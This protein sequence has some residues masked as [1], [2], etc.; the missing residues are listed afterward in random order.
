V[1]LIYRPVESVFDAASVRTFSSRPITL[2][3][4]PELVTPDNV[5]EYAVGWTGTKIK[6]NGDM[7]QGSGIITDRTAINAIE[8]GEAMQVSM[9]YTLKLD[10]TPGKT[11]EGQQY[12]GSQTGLRMNHLAVV[13]RARGGS[14]LKIGDNRKEENRT[15]TVI[16]GGVAVKV[17]DG[18][19]TLTKA[20][21]DHESTKAKLADAEAKA[22]TTDADWRGK[23]K[24]ME[25]EIARLKKEN[26]G[27][28]EMDAA[29]E[30]RAKL[31][32]DAAKIAPAFETK[33]KDA[34][35]IRKGVVASVAGD[36]AVADKSADYIA[37][38][39]DA[40]LDA[41]P[42]DP[43]AAPLKTQAQD[44]DAWGKSVFDAAGVKMK[45]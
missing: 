9:G 40:L 29:V 21:A 11:P 6:R 1:K 23:V 45:G 37:A 32:A 22:A 13:P 19:D 4:P 14:K 31:L 20:L 42:S 30:A 18:V 2:N 43:F 26:M 35:A 38:R 7:I 16:I 12:D 34:D 5:K 36:A 8:S 28:E 44:G 3:H 17:A 24:E 27:A 33:G 25:A 15:T 39:F 10:M 41:G